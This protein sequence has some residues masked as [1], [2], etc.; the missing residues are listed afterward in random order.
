MREMLKGVAS[1]ARI[2]NAAIRSAHEDLALTLQLYQKE[3]LQKGMA[4]PQGRHGNPMRKQAGRSG[5]DAHS[6][7]TLLRAIDS[8]EN[9]DVKINGFSVGF[10][11]KTRAA[12]YWRVQEFGYAGFV[13][14]VI[15]GLFLSAGGRLRFPSANVQSHTDPRLIQFTVDPEDHPGTKLIATG[16]RIRNPIR[17]YH[18]QTRGWDRFRE[19]GFLGAAA[20]E[21][22]KSAFEQRGM[23]FLSRYLTAT[24][25]RFGAQSIH[26][27]GPADR[28][29]GYGAEGR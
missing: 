2:A 8:A 15:P 7:G 28:L 10:L 14:D 9:R 25:K 24:G 21:M 13:G 22:Y 5:S 27:Q 3:E 19:A 18:F 17:G 1:E 29:A 20:T 12:A 23:I 4:D 6:E 11:E 16:V 26:G